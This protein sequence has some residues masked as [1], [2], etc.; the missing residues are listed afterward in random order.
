MKLSLFVLWL[1]LMTLSATAAPVLYD[2]NFITT[3]GI[4]P[5][6]GSF[7]YDSA[8]PAFSSF[9]IVWNGLTFDL[10]STANL[11]FHHNPNAP[12][13]DGAC[14]TP[15][16]DAADLFRILS[17]ECGLEERAW[18]ALVGGGFA[19]Y[20]QIGDFTYQDLGYA[21]AY[22]PTLPNA[23]QQGGQG[24]YTISAVPEPASMISTMVGGILLA[25]R[26]RR[27]PIRT[28]DHPPQ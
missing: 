19:T 18:Y 5:T 21:N 12:F 8:I 22:L 11:P 4:A 27:A 15:A 28:A 13:L 10:T 26:G 17:G 24:T 1:G 7:V 16:A 25:L 3:S 14:N 6:A 20:T 9:T 2:I 23:V